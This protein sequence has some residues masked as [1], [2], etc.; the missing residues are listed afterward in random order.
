MSDMLQCCPEV[1]VMNRDRRVEILHSPEEHYTKD[2]LH[3]ERHG[4]Y[5]LVYDMWNEA[6]RITYCPFCGVK[7]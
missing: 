5:Y 2:D 1:G 7:V 6:Y 4:H 3:P